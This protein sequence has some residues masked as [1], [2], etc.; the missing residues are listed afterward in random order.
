LQG[1]GLI[2]QSL[3]GFQS[4]VSYT[5]SFKA[6]QRGN[7]NQGGQDFDVYLDNTFL[8]T[9]RPAS[10]S[11]ATLTTPT[12]TT[13]TGSHT[14]KFQ[15]RN[16]SGGDNTAFID[17]VRVTAA[18]GNVITV[19][20]V[21]TGSATNYTLSTS[22]THSGNFAQSF[23]ASPSGATLM[24][25]LDAGDLSNNPYVTLYRYDT[26][27]NVYCVEQHGDAAS[28]TGC[29]GTPPGAT[30]TPV[31]PDPNN[32]WRRRLFAYDSLS[33][34]RWTSNPESGTTSYQYDDN[35]NVI[36]KTDARGITINYNPPESPI[37]SLNRVTKK[38]YSNGDPSVVL[39]YDVAPGNTPATLLNLVGR[40][41]GSSVGNVSTVQSYDVIGR[42]A[43]Q[44]QC[45]PL[46]CG[47]GWLRQDY[48]YSLAGGLASHVFD[49]GFTITQTYDSAGRISQVTSTISDAQHPGTLATFDS[50]LG[51]Y[52]SGNLRK[53]TLGNGLTETAAYNNRLQPC[54][55][56]LNSSGSALGQCSDALP[57]GNV[58]D[59]KYGF[60]AGASDNGNLT[61]FAATGFQTFNRTYSY[62]PLNRLSIMSAPG[63]ACSGLSWQYD[64][65][66]NR[67]NQIVTG[68]TCN[69]FQ[70]PG[71]AQ[72]R[73]LGPY[74][75]DAAGNMTNDGTH[76][77]TYDAE[78]QAT[79]VDAG[80]TATYLY[81][82]AGQRVQKITPTSQTNYFLDLD[83]NAAV[84]KDQNGVLLTDYIY[85][86]GSLLAQYKAGTTFFFTRDHLGSTRLMSAIGGTVSDSLD[87]L[88]YGEQIAGGT[89]TTRKFTGK[90]RDAESGLDY[91]GARFD[92]SSLGRFMSP[93]RG[94]MHMENP[95]SLNRYSY[96]LNNP[97]LYVD[98]N[99]KDPLPTNIVV[100]LANFYQQRDQFM[101]Q[102]AYDF[103]DHRT[104][105]PRA[106]SKLKEDIRQ[107]AGSMTSEASYRSIDYYKYQDAVEDYM[108][109]DIVEKVTQWLNDPKTTKED[110]EAALVTLSGEEHLADV[111]WALAWIPYIDRV[112]QAGKAMGAG[113]IRNN[114]I[115]ILEKMIEDA[116]K[117]KEKKEEEE[118]KKKKQHEEECKK[119]KTKC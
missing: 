107:N 30:D 113:G 109:N 67:T 46:N 88:P 11:Y 102:W 66:A 25:G 92:S 1:A 12:F 28:G 41:S 89:G 116:K 49:N 75:Y 70:A 111:P 27:G 73:L 81:N 22:S 101:R 9:F 85:V 55:T 36:T 103:R 64:A 38:T 119:D 100:S 98:P 18:S 35:G 10:S 51:F 71:T 94:A 115:S 23:T 63:D 56:N 6:A 33:R 82:A 95:Q 57:P 74:Q 59:F 42:V 97:L 7:F 87:Y 16:S 118:R 48:A 80:N 99:G 91:F 86:H 20:S 105:P 110:L 93:D 117:A 8:A 58:Q 77:Y 84:E 106:T 17:A 52:P 47:T 31:Q 2:S 68:G 72:N 112:D 65:W 26:L 34:L 104:F 83:G 37:D 29:P 15:G 114:L 78:D 53:M 76:S 79:K 60:N 44:W 19:T 69:P 54:R 61:S 4:G 108:F 24:G 40:L 90:E 96:T 14:L 50:S 43:S 13:T 39:T 45:T 3:S 21:G 32:A 5:V 62:D